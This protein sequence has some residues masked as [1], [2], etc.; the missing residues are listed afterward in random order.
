MGPA[1]TQVATIPKPVVFN[2]LDHDR[3]GQSNIL[4][5]LFDY[6]GEVFRRMTLEEHQRKRAF[7]ADGYLFFLDPTKTSDEQEKPLT[8]F[9]QDVRVVK[10]LKAGQ[11]IRCPVALCVPKIDLMPDQDYARG[12]NVVEQFYDELAS[13]GWGMDAASIQKRS[14]LMRD[15]RDT[16]WPG[17]EIERQIDDLFGGRFMFFPLTPVGLNEPGVGDLSQ[18]NISPVGILHPLLWLLHM[19]GYPV[20]SSHSST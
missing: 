20:L 17:W 7:T 10:G 8:S 3:L 6:S 16:I 13:I 15:L 9:R 1:A 11:Q 12:G 5:N 18:R 19:N 14:E 4:V 2:F